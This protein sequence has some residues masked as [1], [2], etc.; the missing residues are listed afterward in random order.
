MT[1]PASQGATFRV[2]YTAPRQSRAEKGEK[3]TVMVF[4]HGA[5]FSGLSFGQTAAHL[6]SSSTSRDLGFAAVDAR[7][8]GMSL[9]HTDCSDD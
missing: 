1:P 5:G 2:Y 3:P 6:R 8:H 9:H 4:C 7:G